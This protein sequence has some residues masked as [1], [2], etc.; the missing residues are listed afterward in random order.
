MK[1]IT[2]FLIMLFGLMYAGITIYADTA[3][4]TLVVHYYRYDGNYTNFNFWMWEY[5]PSS[6]GGVQH[7]F[8]PNVTDEYGAYVT[9]DLTTDYPTATTVGIIVKQGG[10]DGY[11]EPG[12]DRYIDL[13]NAEQIG[14]TVHAYLVQ[15]DLNIG[16]SQADL[17]NNIPDYRAKVL[18]ASFDSDY[19]IDVTVTHVPTLGYELYE[20][21]VLIDSGSVSSTSF[22]LSPSNVDIT[23]SYSVKVLFDAEWQPS[24]SVSLSKLYDTQAFEDMFT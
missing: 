12:G 11:R 20:N 8:D 7:D 17:N 13:L 2:I 23:K 14:S 10:W 22:T 18:S 24:R 15:G 5:Q 4:T 1:K 9:I 21:H 3:P 6:L 16:T 19:T